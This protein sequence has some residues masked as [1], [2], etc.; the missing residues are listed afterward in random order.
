M[1]AMRKRESQNNQTPGKMEIM[2]NQGILVTRTPNPYQKEY[3]GM[4][5]LLTPRNNI[6]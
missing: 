4:V 1:M 3:H 6:Q 2:K 5:E